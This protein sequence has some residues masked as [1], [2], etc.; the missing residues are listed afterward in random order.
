MLRDRNRN[1]TSTVQGFAVLRYMPE[2][3][4]FNPDHVLGEIRAVL[5]ARNGQ[6]TPTR[7]FQPG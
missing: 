1:N 4:W 3:I 2:H 5:A 6:G 7:A